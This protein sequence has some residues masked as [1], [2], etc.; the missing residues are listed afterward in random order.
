MKIFLLIVTLGSILTG[1][2][3]AS[4]SASFY[5]PKPS[6]PISY[7]LRCRGGNLRFSSTPGQTLSTGEQLMNMTMDFAAGTKGSADARANLSPGQC[8]W[9]DRGFR[10]G[11]PTQVRFEIVYFGQT[12][13][14][15]HGSP[16]DHSA[17]AAE[18][19]PD[20]QNLPQYLSDSSH[21]WSFFVYNTNQ[22]YMQAT[23]HKLFKQLIRLDPN[24]RPKILTH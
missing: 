8:S 19:Y 2:A 9:V 12:A 3:G 11:E 6:R 23:G 13:Q 22:G 10:G 1:A 14:A 20:A 15:R 16:V 21:F 24:G 18:R 5:P 4:P 7:E 17:T